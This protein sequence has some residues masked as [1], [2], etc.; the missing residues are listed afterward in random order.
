MQDYMAVRSFL[1]PNNSFTKIFV[2]RDV[3]YPWI[4]LPI[5]VAKVEFDPRIEIPRN[6]VPLEFVPVNT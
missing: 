1:P 4:L 6:I 3:M 2:F 5:F